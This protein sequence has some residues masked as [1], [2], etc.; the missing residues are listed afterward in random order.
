MSGYKSTEQYWDKAFDRIEVRVLESEK[1]G[2]EGIDTA[3]DWI[4]RTSSV[5]LDFGCGS[6]AILAYLAKRK[7][8]RYHGV[9]ISKG[10]VALAEKLFAVNRLDKGF[11]LVGSVETLQAC[12][13]EDF[14]AV[15][16]SNV[17]DNM[18]PKD[19]LTVLHEVRRLLK[20]GG[21]LL[22]KLNPHYDKKTIDKENLELIE[23]DFYLEPSGLYLWN[24]PDAFW[25]DLLRKHYTIHRQERVHFTED[26]YNRMFLCVKNS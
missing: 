10:A 13:S 2:H 8:G 18:K 6:G 16:L 21:K 3:L 22:V 17:L 9:D 15:V 5:V 23:T 20:P 4:S 19:A 1:S 12:K 7:K 11:F 26:Q 14:D 24:K 25:L